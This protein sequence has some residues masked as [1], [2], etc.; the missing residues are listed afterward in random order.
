MDF[1]D[2]L[3]IALTIMLVI[4]LP[5]IIAVIVWRVTRKIKNGYIR[6][7]IRSVVFTPTLYGHA[8]IVPAFFMGTVGTGT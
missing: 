6:V 3:G 8:G 5:I 4:G 7:I 1:K 2:F